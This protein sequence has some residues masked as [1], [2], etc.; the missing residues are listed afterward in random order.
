[1]HYGLSPQEL[2][3]FASV[4]QCSGPLTD[5]SVKAFGYTV[6]LR[7]VVNGKFAFSPFSLEIMREIITSE[8]S[9]SIR[10]KTFDLGVELCVRP[11]LVVLV[12]VECLVLR[13]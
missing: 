1:V 9:P 2:G 10:S 13:S 7:W 3:Q 12:G 11:S 6:V 5:G 4:Q 8:L